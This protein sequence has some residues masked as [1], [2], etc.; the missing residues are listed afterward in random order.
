MVRQSDIDEANKDENKLGAEEKGIK[1]Q[2][3]CTD[4]PCCLVFSVF[5]VSMIGLSA[6]GFKEGDPYKLFIPFDSV[7]N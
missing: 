6:Y 2:R 5:I 1:W 4:I 3:S 7:G